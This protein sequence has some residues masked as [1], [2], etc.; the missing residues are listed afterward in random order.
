M[1]DALFIDDDG[2]G[3]AVVLLHAF[4]CDS[5]MWAP[6]TEA[7]RAAGFRV[8]VPDLPGFG[9]SV[10]LDDDPSLVRVAGSIL[11]AVESRGV[12]RFVLGGVSLG[13]YVAM[14]MVAAR[15]ELVLGLALCDTKATG[16]SPAA[17]ENRE[18]LAQMCLDAPDE[19]AR[20]LEQAVLPGLLGD[21][22]RAGRPSVVVDVRSWL[23]DARPETVACYQRAM[24]ARPD[25]RDVLA[26]VSAPSLVV[27]GDEDA[28]SP[29]EEQD[30]MLASL[31]DAKLV[32]VE[33]A[34]HLANV[35]RPDAVTAALLGF[36]TRV[37]PPS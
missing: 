25:S 6:Q 4:P 19:T 37:R 22:T 5:R 2:D 14:A 3:I 10:L 16:D 29:R 32:V 8:L 17:S 24:A 7:L 15:P 28:L 26:Q 13:G 9:R 33:K 34:G 12:D 20:I 27:W 31:S 21:T 23:A 18:R 30:L 35:E 1:T 11:R 36:L